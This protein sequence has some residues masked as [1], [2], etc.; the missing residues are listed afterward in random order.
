MQMNNPY[1]DP[2]NH[3]SLKDLASSIYKNQFTHLRVEDLDPDQLSA[4]SEQSWAAAVAFAN[5]EQVCLSKKSKD[6][7][8]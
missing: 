6:N 3:Q 4:L 7:T 2:H 8:P 5:A 1:Y